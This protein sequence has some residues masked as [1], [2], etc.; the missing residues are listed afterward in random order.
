MIKRYL[1]SLVFFTFIVLYSIII[2]TTYSLY[3]DGSDSYQKFDIK[4]MVFL[5]EQSEFDKL[6]ENN[7]LLLYNIYISVILIIDY[8]INIWYNYKYKLNLNHKTYQL[9]AISVLIFTSSILYY[10]YYYDYDNSINILNHYCMFRN[11][12]LL[13]QKNIY[14]VCEENEF[15]SITLFLLCI[16]NVLT[17]V[18]YIIHELNERFTELKIQ[19]IV[20]RN[21]DKAIITIIPAIFCYKLLINFLKVKIENQTYINH[22][23]NCEISSYF[24]IFGSLIVM[25]FVKQIDRL[26]KT[27]KI[28]R[29]LLWFSIALLIGLFIYIAYK[30][31]DAAK[32]IVLIIVVIG[33]LNF[34]F[35]LLIKFAL[36]VISFIIYAYVIN[37]FCNML[38]YILIPSILMNLMDN[39]TKFLFLFSFA[40]YISFDPINGVIW[41]IIIGICIAIL[42]LFILILSEFAFYKKSNT[43]IDFHISHGFRNF[44]DRIRYIFRSKRNHEYN[45]VNENNEENYE[46]ELN[47]EYYSDYESDHEKRD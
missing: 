20:I 22:K 34:T 37:D 7:N 24:L 46:F 38:L 17:K 33:I 44:T 3:S 45:I 21:L 41:N 39:Y 47:D 40:Y 36:I 4:D 13:I 23:F 42:I 19:K 32:S 43:E 26:R 2:Y 27:F 28:I 16:W 25:F 12:A 1:W 15:T 30:Y 6:R 35:R 29:K 9:M 18:A 31:D 8:L 11:D 14:Y 5:I 10:G